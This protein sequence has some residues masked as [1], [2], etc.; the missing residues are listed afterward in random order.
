MAGGDMPTIRIDAD[1]YQWLEQ[2]IK[3][4]DDTPNAVLRRV[5]SLDS[6][7]H[8]RREIRRPRGGATPRNE[9]R[10]PIFRSLVNHGGGAPRSVVLADIESMMESNLTSKDKELIPSGEAVR[11]QKNVE[12]MIYELRKAGFLKS[13]DDS[14]SGYWSLSDKGFSHP[15]AE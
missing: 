6:R 9:F 11:W 1:V 8:E 14:P 10:R 7:G 5:A 2:Q 13:A 15:D 4:F 3:G 12:W